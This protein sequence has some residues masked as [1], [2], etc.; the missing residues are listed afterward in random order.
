ML[1][2]LKD[3]LKIGFD[4][5]VKFLIAFGIG[6]GAGAVVCW[7]YDLPLALSILGGILVL[8]LALALLSDSIFD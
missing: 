1:D 5:L 6:T 4:A 3:L 7:Y 2:F 8:G